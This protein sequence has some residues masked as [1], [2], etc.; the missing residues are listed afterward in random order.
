MALSARSQRLS[1]GDCPLYGKQRP[2]EVAK[3]AHWRTRMANEALGMP[4]SSN[5]GGNASISMVWNPWTAQDPAAYPLASRKRQSEAKRINDLGR[6]I[7]APPAPSAPA[8][9]PS[10]PA[11]APA[12]P[13]PASDSRAPSRLSDASEVSNASTAF[14][15][16]EEDRL[17]QAAHQRSIGQTYLRVGNL[18]EA[19]KHLKEAERLLNT[20][21]KELRAAHGKVLDETRAVVE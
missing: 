16:G 18:K 9:A 11:V 2:N 4:R 15:A 3:V 8:P 21:S 6:H 12:P 19:K 17:V 20:N 5:S 13:P 7:A 14:L 1:N 10:A